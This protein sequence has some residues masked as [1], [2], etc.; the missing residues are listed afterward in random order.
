MSR[1][2]PGSWFMR[3][4]PGFSSVSKLKTYCI[5]KNITLEFVF[6]MSCYVNVFIG[7]IHCMWMFFNGHIKHTQFI[8]DVNICYDYGLGVQSVKWI[9]FTAATR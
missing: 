5:H 3:T 1:C 7:S 2:G 6:R 4:K 8:L 9:N